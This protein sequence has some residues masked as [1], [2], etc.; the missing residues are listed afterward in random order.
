MEI[1]KR[2]G[3]GY[4]GQGLVLLIP[5]G[6]NEGKTPIIHGSLTTK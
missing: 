6:L 5:V 4:M 3:Y 2:K 1:Q